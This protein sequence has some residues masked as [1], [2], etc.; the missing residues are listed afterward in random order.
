MVVMV[1]LLLVKVMGRTQ[2]CSGRVHD[3][4]EVGRHQSV[5]D[6]GEQ[7]LRLP[8]VELHVGQP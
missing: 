2:A 3:G 4:G 5:E 6:L 8:T 1:L 7:V